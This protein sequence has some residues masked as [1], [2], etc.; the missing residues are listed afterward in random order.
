MSPLPKTKRL[1]Q[2]LLGV[3][4]GDTEKDI[5]DGLDISFFTVKRHLQRLYRSYEVPSARKLQR[6]WRDAATVAALCEKIQ[7]MPDSR[8]RRAKS[9]VVRRRK[10]AVSS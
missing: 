1:C 6:L 5:A 2:I 10:H 4:N 9:R 8:C 7:A 3:L